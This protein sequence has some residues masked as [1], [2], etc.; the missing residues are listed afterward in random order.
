[1][2]PTT[3]PYKYSMH[4]EKDCRALDL[5]EAHSLINMRIDDSNHVVMFSLDMKH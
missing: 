2:H 5:L 3:E 4:V 1:M